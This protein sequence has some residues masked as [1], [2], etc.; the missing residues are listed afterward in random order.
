M[1]AL[2]MAVPVVFFLGVI[3]GE[4][5][6][7][8][9]AFPLWCLYIGFLILA[10]SSLIVSLFWLDRE[11]VEDYT[12]DFDHRAAFD[13]KIKKQDTEKN[14]VVIGL[15]LWISGLGAS[16]LWLLHLASISFSDVLRWL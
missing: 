12:L 4:F 10:L 15:G 9:H 16:Y 7:L 8:W 1:I 13:K 14:V 3:L 5:P 11:D 2:L 6:T